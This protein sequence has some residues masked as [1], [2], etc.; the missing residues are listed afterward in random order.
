[1]SEQGASSDVTRNLVTG[2]AVIHG[3]VIQASRIESLTL[4]AY[5][6]PRPRQVPPLARTFVNRDRELAE[7]D[8]AAAAAV[9][10]QGPRT[11]LL[12]GLGGIGKTEL[13]SR[14][15]GSD[16]HLRWF[17]QGQLYVDLEE[18][19]QDGAADVCAVLRDFLLD[20]GVHPDVVPHGR[21]R[22]SS[23]YR[24]VSAN[25]G[26]LVVVDNAQHA[27]EV[28]GLVPS[29]G[30]LVVTSRRLLPALVARDGAHPISVGPLDEG[31]ASR[32]MA[33]LRRAQPS[34]QDA[35]AREA[36]PEGAS[37]LLARL[38]DGVPLAL[39]TVGEWLAARSHLDLDLD[40]TLRSFG[41]ERM[42]T[43]VSSDGSPS[44]SAIL[45]TVHAQLPAPAQRL[46]ALLG[47][48]ELVTFTTPLIRS[49]AGDQADDAVGALYSS[50]LLTGTRNPGRFRP[51]DLVRT[52][53]RALAAR[54]PEE[55]RRSLVSAAV[56][57]YATAAAHADRLAL[58]E[59]R[60]RLQEPP[61]ALPPGLFETGAEALDWLDD[62]RGNLLPVVRAAMTHEQYDEVWRLCESLWAWFHSRRPYAVWRP[63]Q[64]CGVEA[65]QW[66]GR[67]DAE[68]RMRNQLARH[69]YQQGLHDS[70]EQQL[71]VAGT[72]C[73]VVGHPVLS[74]MVHETRG[75]IALAQERH[76]DALS[77]FRQALDANEQADDRH[78][79]TVQTYNLAQAHVAAGDFAAALALLEEA[80]DRAAGSTML[81]RIE[82]VRARV[83]RGL[84]S[85][86]AALEAAVTGAEQAAALGWHTKLDETLAFLTGLA[87]DADTADDSRLRRA[88]DAKLRE[89][90]QIVG[91]VPDGD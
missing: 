74:G 30:L 44:M 90:R 42:L 69:D 61:K 17:P 14:W 50:H 56:A 66:A 47:A 76:A 37:V 88:C 4:P 49:V 25:G 32:L 55:E 31:A 85:R 60:F 40:E 38:C 27:A 71:S 10:G 78:G 41:P 73:E 6:P 63:V 46:Y 81:T 18:L 67:R 3:S 86:E 33:G 8:A 58:G 29:T 5:E 77:L 2:R 21:R 36:L 9:S 26:L 65:A 87:G 72:L 62:E 59:A 19:R 35:A 22:L 52:H 89:L 11:V 28:R 91:A 7:L 43:A 83:L 80:A 51:H 54:L 16:H 20:L 84:G 1:M 48:A 57:F 12:S 70:A 75:L 45:D 13:L 53:A 79:V 64:E 39:L 23:L 82:L 15:T 24:S 34:R 68:I